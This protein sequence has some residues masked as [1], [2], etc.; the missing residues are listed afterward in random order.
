MVSVIDLGGLKDF[1]VSVGAL[2]VQD[3]RT[4]KSEV[5]G[6]EKFPCLVNFT[7]SYPK[8]NP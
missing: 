8:G 1:L 5:L 7:H 2:V 6:R 4:R 3:K